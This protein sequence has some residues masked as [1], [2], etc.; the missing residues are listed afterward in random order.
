MIFRRF[1]EDVLAQA[2]YLIGCARAGE[3]EGHPMAH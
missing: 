1:Y 3:A 2:S